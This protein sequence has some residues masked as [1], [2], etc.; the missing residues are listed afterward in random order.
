MA[1][2]ASRYWFWVLDVVI[3]I[4]FAVIGRDSHG[5]GSD[6]TETIRIAT[7][8]LMAYAVTV[9]A[10]KAWHKPLRFSTGLVLAASTIV[11]GMV[12]RRFVFDD[13]TAVAFVLVTGAWLTGLM[14]AWRLAAYAADRWRAPTPTPS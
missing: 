13:G 14:F 7:P 11:I 12:L 6:A 4:S 2:G 9:L 10:S 8:F 3:S 5:F 1:L